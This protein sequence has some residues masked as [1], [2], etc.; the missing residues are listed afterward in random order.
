V[1]QWRALEY[2]AENPEA[3][4]AVKEYGHS[5]NVLRKKALYSLIMA[6]YGIGILRK[7]K[8]QN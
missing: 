7:R 8:K 3:L 5:F 2:F 6:G 1:L 4:A